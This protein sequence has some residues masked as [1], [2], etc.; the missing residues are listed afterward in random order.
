MS[1]TL[2]CYWLKFDLAVK[3]NTK[4][5]G[6]T[7]EA[8]KQTKTLRIITFMKLLAFVTKHFRRSYFFMT[9]KRVR[10]LPRPA[11]L[12][13]AGSTSGYSSW[14]P[15]SSGTSAVKARWTVITLGCADNLLGKTPKCLHAQG[16]QS[17][18]GDSRTR[19][20]S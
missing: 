13:L 14:A 1:T 6:F 5:V 2:D 11:G 3:R 19:N 12:S 18:M 16:S 10:L 20:E 8:L 9:R 15:G 4:C 17:F 7:S